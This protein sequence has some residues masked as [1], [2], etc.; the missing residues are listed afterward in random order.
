M[1]TR[2]QGDAADMI[3]IL[4]GRCAEH[5]WLTPPEIRSGC[6]YRCEFPELYSD[7]VDYAD[8]DDD[9]LSE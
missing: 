2:H 7:D 3:D 1:T 5:G 8:D 9:D 4:T 6:C